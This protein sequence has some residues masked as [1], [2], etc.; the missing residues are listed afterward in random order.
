MNTRQTLGVIGAGAW[1][2]ALANIAARAGCRT[3]LWSFEPEIAEQI[4]QNLEN[5]KYLPGIPLDPAITATADITA[6]CKNS[7]LLLVTPVQHSRT[8]MAQMAPHVE[9]GTPIVLCSKGIE[10][11]TGHLMSQVTADTLPQSHPVI[12]SGPS[13]AGEVAKGLP[14]AVTL[15]A[16]D[17]AMGKRIARVLN[18][19]TFRLYLS[20]DLIG[21]Q[22]GGAVKNVLA[23][24]CGIVEGRKLGASASAALT[25]RGFAELTRLAVAL[26][27]R[28]ETLAGL[29][30]LGDLILTCGSLQS[31]NMSLGAALGQGKT[32]EQIMQSRQ[33]VSEGVHTAKIILQK[34]ATAGV[35][36]P[37]CAAVHAILH[38]GQSVGQEITRLLARPMKD[39]TT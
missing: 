18:T 10:I 23:I 15:A 33:S 28:R 17:A 6:A 29:S 22:I 27:A 19:A 5:N 1:G 12:L 16:T 25:A 26:G 14:T 20:D 7:I 30:G 32:L 11:R 2:T 39:E 13:F 3:T 31:R 36:M 4:T 37:I 35:E 8:I 34:A 21:A 9:A 24:A 38:E